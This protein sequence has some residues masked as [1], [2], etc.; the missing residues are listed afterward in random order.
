MLAIT[1]VTGKVGGRVA[2]KL[3]ELGIEQRLIARDPSRVPHLPGVEV[4]RAASYG[5][6][7][8]LGKALRGV[9]TFLLVAARDRFGINHNAAMKGEIP[10]PYNRLQQQL[11]AVDAA[12]AA[13][14]RHII[15]LSV[16]NAAAD[17]TF[18]LGA[19]HYY[20]EEHIRE[21]G[22]EYTFLRMSLYTDNV[23]L[24]VTSDGVIRAPSGEGRAAW[25]TRADVADSAVAVLTGKGRENRIYDLTGPQALTMSETALILSKAVGRE[26]RYV[27]QIP[28]EARLYRNTS[29]ME[30]YERERKQ[31]TGK[32]LDNFEVEMFVTHFLQIAVGELD[33]VSDAVLRL[34]G[35][36]PQ[37]LEDFLRLH[38]ES[39]RHLL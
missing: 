35:R 37:S 23:P 24:S 30:T 15:Y 21:T 12:A 17:S 33:V 32:G 22:L 18:I 14:V 25:V 16:L 28:H 6:A 38:P 2:A 5:D 39:Y 29:R 31:H 1:G 7:V 34:T 26:I 36:Q 4:C 3:S 13:G 27:P 19:D 20:T 10:P 8:S 11:T 9:D